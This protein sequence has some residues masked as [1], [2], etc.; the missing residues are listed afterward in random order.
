LCDTLAY[1]PNCHIQIVDTLIHRYVACRLP[2]NGN[3]VLENGAG[4]FPYYPLIIE[5]TDDVAGFIYRSITIRICLYDLFICHHVEQRAD[6]HNIPF[7]R[8]DT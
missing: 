8:S 1:R 4:F 2:G 7:Q 3:V 5:A 6:L